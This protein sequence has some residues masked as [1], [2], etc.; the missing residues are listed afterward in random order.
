MS[1]T[2]LVRAYLSVDKIEVILLRDA[3]QARLQIPLQAGQTIAWQGA[4][5]I[6]SF[7]ASMQGMSNSQNL[8]GMAGSAH[9][10][11]AA[12]QAAWA[13]QWNIISSGS[14]LFGYNKP[15]A[16]RYIGI[17]DIASETRTQ[18]TIELIN[19]GFWAIVQQ[20]GLAYLLPRPAVKMEKGRIHC[21]TGPAVIWPD[22]EASHEYYLQGIEVPKEAILEPKR[23]PG[24]A[25]SHPNAEV[26]RVLA[27]HYGF[28]KLMREIGKPVAKDDYGRLWDLPSIGKMVEV[29]NSTP[30][31]DGSFRDYFLRVPPQTK[32]AHE[33]VA[34]TFGMTP[35]EYQ[36][37][38][39]T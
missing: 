34:W 18:A 31:P 4:S 5:N 33:A 24:F 10:M 16:M 9:Q 6:G 12:G 36:P 35:K 20:G 17:E 25:I 1:L 23:L 27:A 26:R 30:E 7:A 29:R 37:E 15:T 39:Q 22:P 2:E 8:L 28:E 3:A 21:S 38:R 13:A 32:T 11:A 19:A 14:R